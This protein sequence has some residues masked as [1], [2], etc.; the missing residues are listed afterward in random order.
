MYLVFISIELPY[1]FLYFYV[2]IKNPWSPDLLA[3][4]SKRHIP[5]A[6]QGLLGSF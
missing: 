6:S 4:L 5:P 3:A 2:F 1:L